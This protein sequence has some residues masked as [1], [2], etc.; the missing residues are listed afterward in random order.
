[1]RIKYIPLLMLLC[2]LPLA[3]DFK[4][5]ESGGSAA[6]VFLVVPVLASGFLLALSGPRFRNSSTLRTITVSAI[7]LTVI[8]SVIPQL[9]H[10]NDPGNYLRVL[11]SFLLFM[12]GFHIGCHPWSDD[13]LLRFRR[14]F[15]VSMSLSLIF[16]FLHGMTSG[17]SITDARFKI[18]TPMLLGFQGYLLYDLVTKRAATRVGLAV[19]IITLVIELLSVTRSF[20]LG[21][22]LLFCLA[23][24]IGSRSLSSL[25]T[26]LVRTSAIGIVVVAA[27][28]VTATIVAPNVME[29]W[30]ERVFA[31]EATSNGKD[32]T[33]LSRLAEIEGQYD[34]VT[35]SA[36]NLIFGMGLGHEYHFAPQ[37]FY[38]LISTQAFSADV[39]KRRFTWEA[40]H[41][42]WVY[43]LY[44]GG[45]AFGIPL[46]A[47]VILAFFLCVIR[48]KKVRKT[49]IDSPY[50]DALGRYLMVTAGMIAETIGGNPLGPRYNGIIYGIAF[51]IMVSA[52]CQLSRK[53]LKIANSALAIPAFQVKNSSV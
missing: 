42:F 40:G 36:T 11:L 3:L 12:M 23:T 43:Q 10:G 15:F 53:R 51:G 19:F 1:M 24:W 9:I 18:V 45:M 33:T 5:D 35:S 41:N 44:S 38:E 13:R 49:R 28:G 31:F 2:V 32:P 47:A 52:Y 14:L 21:T 50:L 25:T 48:Y 8:G 22:I 27:V 46:P 7:T 26:T 4:G 16:T 30:S 37:Y 17:A 6:Q 29:K 34:Q 20:M 39:L